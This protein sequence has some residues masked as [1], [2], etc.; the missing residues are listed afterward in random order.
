MTIHVCNVCWNGFGFFRF[1]RILWSGG[2]KSWVGFGGLYHVKPPVTV[3]CMH[4]C[5]RKFHVGGEY[6]ENE[7]HLMITE[8]SNTYHRK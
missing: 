6:K 5:V 2:I 7:T 8:G 1:K 3:S 4:C